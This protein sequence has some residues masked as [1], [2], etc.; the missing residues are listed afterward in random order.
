MET[1][2]NTPTDTPERLFKVTSTITLREEIDGR[3]RRFDGV[4]VTW[5]VDRSPEEAPFDVSE[6]VPTDRPEKEKLAKERQMD[7]SAT[8]ALFTREEALRFLGDL[9]EEHP[10]GEHRLQSVPL[11]ASEEHLRYGPG[12]SQGYIEASYIEASSE[13]DVSGDCYLQEAEREGWEEG[14][15]L[16]VEM[17]LELPEELAERLDQRHDVASYLR[18]LEETAEA[19]SEA[20]NPNNSFS[21]DT[22]L[23]FWTDP[24]LPF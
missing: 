10:E 24:D 18:K 20:P 3:T 8:A 2:T 12:A 11:P 15:T 4:P 23:P 22:D 13:F 1:T 17:T 9:E 19:V 6:V 14:E 7:A 16:L 21:T 5:E